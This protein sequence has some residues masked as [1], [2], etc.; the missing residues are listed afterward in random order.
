M[1]RDGNLT[2]GDLAYFRARAKNVGLVITGAAVVSPNS[3]L[4]NR[5]LLEAWEEGNRDM[6]LRR[7]DDV[8]AHGSKI[9]GQILHLGREMIGGESDFAP[10]APSAM[11]SARDLYPPHALDEA[12]IQ[13]IIEDFTRSAENFLA[14]GYDGIE[15][16]AAHGYLLAQF[17]SPAT[18]D[19]SDRWGG[20]PERR[21]RMLIEVVDRMRARSGA[22][23]ILGVRLSADEEIP[24]GLGI[25]DAVEI[26]YALADTGA[27]DYLN[28]TIGT[29]GAYVK[30]AN[31][32]EAIA[33]EAGATIRR[34]VGLPV[35]LAQK[36][37]TPERG[38]SLLAEGAADVIGMA[39][40]FIADAEFATKAASG[41][42]S[43]IRP[44]VGLNQDC[45]SFAPH[46]HCAVNVEAGRETQPDFGP[47]QQAVSPRRIAVIGG[48]P[49]GME[50]ARVAAL[51]GHRVTLFEA[52]SNLGGQF[53]LAASL[54]HRG[55]L[56]S[57]IEHLAGELRHERVRV[58]LGTRVDG[59]EEIA[60][61]FD[62]AIVATGAVPVELTNAPEG[63]TP[64]VSWW[65][66][67]T[68][69]APAPFGG[70]TATFIDDG[71]GF[72]TSYGVAEMLAEAGWRV[73]FTTPS[74]SVG[75]GIP[76][77]SI[78]PLLVR[79][80]QAGT[81]YRV[82]TGAQIIGDGRVTLTNLTS[83][84]DEMHTCDLVVMQTGR[85]TSLPR[86]SSG[87]AFELRHVGDCVT[88][89]RISHAMFEAQRAAR[90]I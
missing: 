71:S 75:V 79:L 78:G 10:V 90:A 68:H 54:P 76:H 38:E 51:R 28:I 3:A 17:L 60:T 34:E 11:R 47:L 4:R 21:R 26:G 37:L 9:V 23:F 84:E 72:W 66:I 2:D 12:E 80:G 49:A 22:D 56:F 81:S 74:A 61:Q 58:E 50:A 19:R 48:G 85:R 42:S 57:I 89:R 87:E 41:R 52:A 18:N 36:I 65:D 59:V 13:S 44:C 35:V 46:L 67:L 31:V 20:S 62:T 25:R 88:P 1:V 45:R 55:Q 39:R 24:N 8:H 7:C 83:G 40:S 27:V 29:R 5:N 15:L 69:G 63:P 30:D 14:A 53:L 16:H 6:L 73:V 64:V 77:E 70:A 43:R 86:R 32:P 33:A 82:L